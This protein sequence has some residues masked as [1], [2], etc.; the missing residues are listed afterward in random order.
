MSLRTRTVRAGAALALAALA[1][2]AGTQSAGTSA[3]TADRPPQAPGPGAP[4]QQRFEPSWESLS[5]YEVPTWFRDAKFG[6]WAHWGPQCQPEQGDWYARQ[7]Y[8]PHPPP[9]AST[10]HYEFHVRTYGHPSKYGFKDVIHAWKAENWNPDELVALYKRAGAQYFMALANHHDN[11]DLWDSTHQPWNS[12][13]V[14]PQKD[15]V[16]GW[17]RAAR[18]QGLRFGV[19]VHASHALTWYEPSQAS[20][21]EGPLAGVPYDGKLTRADGKGLWWEG[22]DPQDLY[23]QNHP[24][25]AGA[26]EA[27]TLHRQWEWGNGAAAPDAAYLERFFRRTMDLID[28]ARPD[29]LYFDDTVL[30]FHPVSDVGLK[31]A[32][33]YYNRSRDWHDGRVEGVLFGKVLGPE[34]RKALVWDVERGA[35]NDLQPFAWQTDTCLGDW[36]YRRSLF[37]EHG[38]KTTTTVIQT[39]ADIVSKNGNLL[40]NVP[41]RGDGTIDDDERRIVEGIGRW[42]DVN[43]EAIF[44]TRP[45]TSYGEGPAAASA[46]PLTG[47]G[48]NEGKRKPYTAEDVRFTAKGDVLYAIVLAWPEDGRVTIRSWASG[49]SSPAA[50]KRRVSSLTL[51]GSAARVPWKRTQRG[52]EVRVPAATSETGVF[53]LKATLR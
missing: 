21:K 14:G 20:D 51:L 41:V 12:V 1:M 53:V 6:I 48:F 11:F 33:E 42:M 52:L 26:D 47:P 18:A 49:G 36:H 46:A 45:W 38:Y 30:P 34:H 22:L 5:R 9:W 16:A 2:P 17:G 39:L 43:G 27:T 32:A 29:L 31:I 10:N 8:L 3:V 25:S 24:R 15:I 40:L 44:G 23:A 50:L 13:R 28:T 4:S 37:E 35:P 19:S 7:M